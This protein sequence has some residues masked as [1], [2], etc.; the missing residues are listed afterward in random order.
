MI[1]QRL[2]HYRILEKIGAGG[3]GE[4]YRARDE[5][6]ERDVALKIL[7]S[8]ML[9]EESARK[10]F[11]KEALALAKLN[12]PNIATIFDFDTQDGVDFLAMEHV[13]GLSLGQKLAAG[14]LGAGE[15][16]ELGMQIAAALE[17]AGARGI[18]HRDLKPQNIMVTAKGQAKVLDFGLARLVQPGSDATVETLTETGGG[19]IA[20]TLPYMA[21]EQLRGEPGDAR[22][23]L[24]ALGAVLYEMATGQRPFQA[25]LATALA[26]DIQHKAAVPPR[27][28][29]P[30]ICERFEDVILKCLKKAPEKRYQ[31]AGEVLAA[32]KSIAT[33]SGISSVPEPGV[34]IRR[35]RSRETR[36]RRI[37]SLVVLPLVNLS[38]DPEQEYF[39]DGMTDALISN[40]AKLRALKIISRTSAMR[41]KGMEKSLPEIA[42]E[43]DV[44][45]VVEGSVLRAGERVRITAQLIHA[46]TD[47]HLWAESYERDLRDVLLLQSEL[48]RAIAGEIQVAITPEERRHLARVRPVNPEAYEAYLKGRFHWLK[49]SREHLDTALGYFQ[50][51][52]EKDPNYALAY[53]GTGYAWF[54]R[55]DTGVLPPC[56]ALPRAE[57]AA[58][59]AAELDDNLS[60][61]HELLASVKYICNRDW[62]GAEAEFRRAIQL[63]PNSAELRLFYSHFLI[64]TGRV[65]EWK[66]EIERALELDPLNF[67]IQCFFGWQLVYLHRYDEAIERLRRTLRAEPNF[68][69]A[70]LGLWGAFYQKGVYEEALTEAKAFFAVLG[71]SEIAEALSQGDGAAD[72]SSVMHLAAEKLVARSRQAY[73]PAMRIARLYA[74]AGE[75]DPALEWLEKAFEQREPALAHLRVGWDWE[76]LRDEPRFLDLLR[77][78]NFP[79]A[80]DRSAV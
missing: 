24:W 61:V 50:L 47:T 76:V 75:K 4:V 41:Y 60:E 48:A 16:V 1:G 57:A 29:N 40:L 77:K 51:A 70:H 63:N 18:I 2:G 25:K 8:G 64:V 42:E 80:R 72:Y 3:M 52:L 39:A 5:R 33:P 34:S 43:L 9:N 71:D 53:V 28:L 19:G 7:P 46:A 22:S 6:L 78:M 31:S 12:H 62:A 49:L 69:S 15:A 79:S 65:Q 44:D 58:L 30:T 59:K 11:R 14:P 21:P 54:S 37:R 38:R 20:G 36:R 68:S 73:V 74:H 45:A 23:D 35:R 17:E 55:A 26:A 56:E 27:R 10:R 32:L 67:F 13:A 66:P